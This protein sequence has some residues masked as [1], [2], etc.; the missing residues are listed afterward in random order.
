[1][2]PQTR[3]Q[4]SIN[5]TPLHPTLSEVCCI[6]DISFSH[7]KAA[8]TMRPSTLIHKQRHGPWLNFSLVNTFSS[9]EPTSKFAIKSYQY[10]KQKRSCSIIPNL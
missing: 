7:A 10:Q 2:T 9:D 1:M 3:C 6:L 5:A 4:H 8:S